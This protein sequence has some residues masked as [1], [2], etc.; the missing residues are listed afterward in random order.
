MWHVHKY[1]DPSESGAIL[2]IVHINGFKISERTIYRCM[3]NQE[4]TALFACAFLLTSDRHGYE[5]R[6]VEGLPNFDLGLAA[7]LKWAV[8]NAKI[9]RSSRPGT[10]LRSS[11]LVWPV[12]AFRVV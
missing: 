5:V 7:S 9:R 3:D 8:A 6:F 2:P 11:S 12:V 4:L 1:I 10:A